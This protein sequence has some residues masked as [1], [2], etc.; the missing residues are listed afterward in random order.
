MRRPLPLLA[1]LG[2]ALLVGGLL[3]G[4][5]DAAGRGVRIRPA[6]LPVGPA[7]AI[8][9]IDGTALVDGDVRVELG[10]D[11]AILLG[12][13][14]KE[15]VVWLTGPDGT[16]EIDAYRP[17]GGHRVLVANA[18]ASETRLSD[19]GRLLVSTHY[20]PR[21][22]RSR[23]VVRDPASG[24]VTHRLRFAGYVDVVDALGTRLLLSQERPARTFL[25]DLSTGAERTLSHRAGSFGDL[26]T[27]LFS[28][29]TKDP[30]DGGC[31]VLARIKRPRDT[32]WRSCQ[33]RVYAVSPDGRRLLT[34]DLLSDGLGPSEL[35]LRRVDGRL[36][37]RYRTRP[38]FGLA[39]FEP[40]GAVVL[41]VI[42]VD[43]ETVGWARC[44]RAVCE[45]PAANAVRT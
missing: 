30:Y 41:E 24:A 23:V 22:A 7:L 11:S 33:E 8:P 16:Q 14:G 4:P 9:H 5:A 6:A 31:V 26:S 3:A 12:R 10:V 45:R 29:Y 35:V 20:A 37:Q 18:A 27:G 39:S 43:V 21:A 32:V 17:D 42:D 36:L 1:L 13:A 34:V 2:S 19:D 28:T 38:A 44:R 25:H 40:G 15:Y